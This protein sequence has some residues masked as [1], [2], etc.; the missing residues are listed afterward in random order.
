MEK[1]FIF[2]PSTILM[3]ERKSSHLYKAGFFH[4]NATGLLFPIERRPAF[5][6]RLRNVIPRASDVVDSGKPAGRFLFAGVNNIHNYA[7]QHTHHKRSL[8]GSHCAISAQGANLPHYSKPS[9]RRT[10][11]RNEQFR[12]SDN[13]NRRC[14][15]LQKSK[16]IARAIQYI[17]AGVV[18]RG[19]STA[20]SA[21]YVK[22]I[23]QVIH[24]AHFFTPLSCCT[25]AR[26]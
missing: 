17:H 1:V 24:K 11:G 23:C 9:L 5:T 4:S 6:E 14:N 22:R 16:R 8:D 20:R 25:S 12:F 3:R 21:S 2:V 7:Y 26:V 18:R 19:L 13:S 15:I 10:T